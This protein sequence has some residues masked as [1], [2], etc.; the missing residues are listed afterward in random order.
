[1]KSTAGAPQINK[2][3]KVLVLVFIVANFFA[4][5]HANL[6]LHFSHRPNRRKQ[7][8]DKIWFRLEHLRAQIRKII[9]ID[10]ERVFFQVHLP[11]LDD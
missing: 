8:K 6:L 3:A 2:K 11:E 1:M 5:A 9:M 10:F 4:Y 7:T